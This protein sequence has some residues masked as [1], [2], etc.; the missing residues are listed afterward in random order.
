MKE[1]SIW[2]EFDLL[3][4]ELNQIGVP[5]E[6]IRSMSKGLLPLDVVPELCKLCSWIVTTDKLEAT[7]MFD[8]ITTAI[9][10]TKTEITRHIIRAELI[11]SND[12]TGAEDVEMRELF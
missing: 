2:V 3:S 7:S 12:E 11:S 8:C 4:D 9:K 10:I 5:A 6:A 1:Y